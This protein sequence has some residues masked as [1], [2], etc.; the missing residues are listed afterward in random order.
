MLIYKDLS[1]NQ[2]NRR[3]DYLINLSTPKVS[4]I[5]DACNMRGAVIRIS[6]AATE[7]WNCSGSGNEEG[8]IPFAYWRDSVHW[9]CQRNQIPC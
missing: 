9:Q 3:F 6:L 7:K 1:N 5:A 8:E 2:K 4:P